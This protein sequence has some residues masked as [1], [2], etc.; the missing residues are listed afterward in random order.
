MSIY[1]EY[2]YLETTNF[3][4]FLVSFKQYQ[5]GPETAKPYLGL[6]LYYITL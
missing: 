4:S 2:Y 5:I 3:E 1:K 6:V